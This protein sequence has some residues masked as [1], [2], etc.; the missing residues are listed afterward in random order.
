M[1]T[2]LWDI[3]ELLVLT[4]KELLIAQTNLQN[5]QAHSA[6]GLVVRKGKRG[7]STYYRYVKDGKRYMKHIPEEKVEE[8]QKQILV[9]RARER[10]L[11]EIKKELKKVRSCLNILRIDMK[12]HEEEPSP[13]I[14]GSTFYPENLKHLTLGGDYVRSKSEVLLANLLFFHKIPYEYEKE[15]TL[16][17]QTLRPDFTITLP[18]GEK[19]FWEH[20]GMLDDDNYAR[21]WAVKSRTYIENGIAEG[22]GLIITR[23]QNGTFDETDAVLKIKTYL[24]DYLNHL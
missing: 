7:E 24:R 1:K 3:E 2:K 19:I 22:S 16:R 10:K 9:W 18:D 11:V 17:G 5:K 12:K 20:L 13:A 15:I 4:Y 6:G 14:P 21:R 23:D 8:Y